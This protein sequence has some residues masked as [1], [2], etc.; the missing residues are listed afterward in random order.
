MILNELIKRLETNSI[1]YYLTKFL[2]Q[3]DVTKIKQIKNTNLVVYSFGGF[4]N[5]ERERIIIQNASYAIPANDD[6]E[7]SVIK[8]TIPKI[9]KSITH[10]NILGLLMSL[11]IK[12][13][14]LGDIVIKDNEYYIYVVKEMVS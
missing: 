2:T 8:I 4:S 9:D 7:I 6:F 14:S 5:S 12:R 1:D 13:E 11:G 10:R 3:E